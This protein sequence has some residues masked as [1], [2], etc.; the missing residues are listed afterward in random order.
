M[1]SF[2]WDC[3][4]PLKDKDA[5]EITDPIGNVHRIHIACAGDALLSFRA[6]DYEE[7]DDEPDYYEPF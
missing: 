5:M 6:S 3:G 2:C 1:A 4:K 7:Y